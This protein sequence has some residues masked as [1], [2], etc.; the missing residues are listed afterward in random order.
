MIITLSGFAG[1][2]KSTLIEYAQKNYKEYF[3]APESAREVNETTSY[4]NLKDESG[5]IFQK[6][7]MDNEFVKLNMVF[8]NNIND[9][10]FDRSLIDNL[11]FAEMTYG[12]DNLNYDNIQRHI[13][14]FRKKY[15]REYIY[16]KNVLIKIC[17]NPDMVAELLK[18]DLRKKTTDS[19]V[20]GFIK[21]G[22]EW[23]NRYIE[24]LNK[25]DG[26]TQSFDIVEHF[27]KNK[28]FITYFDYILTNN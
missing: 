13:D 6:S 23:E 17:T 10:I 15:D 27:S 24:I 18:D 14:M 20:S 4:F 1:V 5:K 8:L 25:L 2:G 16:D 7:I 3:I 19:D 28:N 21:K 9:A 11:T 26:I 12:K 22:H